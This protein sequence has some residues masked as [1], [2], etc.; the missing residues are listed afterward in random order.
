[1][2]A[3]EVSWEEFVG[4]NQVDKRFKNGA[5]IFIKTPISLRDDNNA[6]TII[7]ATLKGLGLSNRVIYPRAKSC[8]GWFEE[9]VY[10]AARVDEAGALRSMNI[11]KRQYDDGRIVDY[12]GYGSRGS[13]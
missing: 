2:Q 3:I 8:C 13:R 11:T 5:D 1:M 4:L 6:G 7:L 12:Q 9:Q 10:I